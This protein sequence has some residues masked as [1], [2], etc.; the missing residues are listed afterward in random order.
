MAGRYEIPATLTTCDDTD[1]D[2]QDST[3]AAMFSTAYLQHVSDILARL[4]TS[5][6]EVGTLEPGAH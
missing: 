5:A 2:L 1:D 3:S 6:I 4:D